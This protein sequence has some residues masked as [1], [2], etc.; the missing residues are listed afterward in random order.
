MLTPFGLALRKVRLDRNLRL[1]DLAEQLDQSTSFISAIETGRKP[2]PANYVDLICAALRLPPV[3]RSLLNSAAD[4]T[5][6]EV[7]VDGLKAEQREWVAEFARRVD[8]VPPDVVAWLKKPIFKSFEDEVPFRRHR[9]LLVAPVSKAILQNF[10][11]DVRRA[12]LPEGQVFF[13]I[14]DVLEFR[15]ESLFPGFYV[16]SCEREVMGGDE[17]RVV[18]GQ[19]MIMLRRDVFDD[20]SRHV[21]R[22]RFTACHELGH[23]LMHRQVVMARVREDSHPIYRDAEWQA[24]EFAGRLLMPLSQVKSFASAADA[25][26]KCGMSPEAARVMMS[27]YTKEAQ[28]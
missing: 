19:N 13:P 24:D 1:V 17:G 18:S 6:S 25:A 27:K 15:M 9:G 12:L 11:N 16:E 23:F 21:G 10:A 20:A 2:I 22:A 5:R 4:Q 8:S 7:K 14:M 26:R 28:M 3:E